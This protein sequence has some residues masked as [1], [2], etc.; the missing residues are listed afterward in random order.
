MP[1]MLE[2]LGFI[3]FLWIAWAVLKVFLIR[4]FPR[5]GLSIAEERYN[6]DPDDINENLVW[7]ARSRVHDLENR[8]RSLHHPLIHQLVDSSEDCR[9]LIRAPDLPED[10]QFVEK[11]FWSTGNS[12]LIHHWYAWRMGRAQHRYRIAKIRGED[13][14]TLHRL[15]LEFKRFYAKELEW[16][17][18]MQAYDEQNNR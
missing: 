3:V 10:Y 8:E 9:Y 1:D 6:R 7:E 5:W 11:G 14:D 17:M 2:L 18:W 13:A 4:V 12:P 16:G 15:E